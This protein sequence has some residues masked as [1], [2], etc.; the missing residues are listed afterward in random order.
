MSL[1]HTGFPAP[2]WRWI[3]ERL[4]GLEKAFEKT[5][6]SGRAEDDTRIRILVVLA[7]FVVGFSFLAVGATRRALFSGGDGG[8][9]SAGDAGPGRAPL[10]DR[11]GA[12]L[13]VDL[14]Y[15][16]LYLDPRDVW[17]RNE[18]RRGLIATLPDLPPARIDKALNASRRTFLAGPLS[19]RDRDRVHALG[20]PGLSFE[21][22]P[23]RV[24][25]LGDA[26]AHLIG[27]SDTGGEGLA[28][29]EGAFNDRIRAGAGDRQPT[30]L[31]IDVR[32]QAALDEELG[33]AATR[34]QAKG[35]V[36]LI[37]NVQTGEVLAMSSWP[38][39]D[40]NHAGASSPDQLRNRAVASVYEM[41]STFKVFT[42]AIGLD[43]HRIT[44]ETVLNTT[45]GVKL[46]ARVI[47]DLH[48]VGH[49]MT[50]RDVFLKSSNIGASQ[51]AL[52]VGGA[53]M[54]RYF[55]AFGLFKAAPIE[56][57]ESARPIVPRDWNANTI[58]SASFG[59]AISVSPAALAAGIGSIMNGGR[60]LPLTLQPM[61]PG[62]RPE[63]RRVVS[64]DTSRQMLDL[65][66]GNV[67][68][69]SGRR[70]N[71]PGLRVGG[72]TGSAEKVVAGHYA[73]DKVL[74]SFAS[75]FPTDGALTD[76]R[77]MVLIIIDE[78]I[79]DAESGGRVG[80]LTAAPAA[81]KVIDR[82]A[83]FLGVARRFDQVAAAP[84][85]AVLAAA[86]SHER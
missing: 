54:T 35:A 80:G 74:A 68:E 26:A 46:G 42:L 61:R 21:R 52:Q 66:R 58:A 30:P 43:T 67:L 10:V 53:D 23:R 16:T 34:L 56:L 71:V 81:G 63:G 85:P 31:S 37:T 29:A 5:R 70:A 78:P 59:H 76:D 47:R 39:F 22:E 32:V 18:V 1:I 24:Y 33:A 9:L 60:Y 13:A 79:A 6:A 57:A 77:Y 15:Y 11:Q 36:G 20:L 44:P 86:D 12:L 82:I 8:G 84:A 83:P 38:N 4:W 7:L 72:K 40:P 62:A 28:G 49:N 3:K 19:P 65:M 64:E 45:Q 41:G 25:P 2:G 50:A 48:A 17:D 14:P 55:D 75:V 27:F 69:G 51:I 73:K